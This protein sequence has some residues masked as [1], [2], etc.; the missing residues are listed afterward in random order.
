MIQDAARSQGV[1]VWQSYCLQEQLHHSPFLAGSKQKEKYHLL[2]PHQGMLFF[3]ST[4]SPPFCSIPLSRSEAITG[5]KH[6]SLY[7][8]DAPGINEKA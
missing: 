4:F 1:F 6:S 2:V 8:Q 3:L 7:Q 5:D